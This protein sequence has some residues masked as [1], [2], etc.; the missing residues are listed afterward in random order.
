M[1]GEIGIR[2]RLLVLFGF[3]VFASVGF[4][5]VGLAACWSRDKLND[6]DR[7]AGEITKQVGKSVDAYM[8]NLDQLSIS[9][10]YSDNIQEVL[11]IDYDAHVEKYASNARQ[12]GWYL[13]NTKNAYSGIQSIYVYDLQGYLFSAPMT[14]V[15][16]D[17]QIQQEEWDGREV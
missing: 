8:E 2:N 15:N 13:A 16:T 17:Y 5:A 4:C 9:A 10:A 12:A 1:A 11:E 6:F 14:F 7:Y 3:L